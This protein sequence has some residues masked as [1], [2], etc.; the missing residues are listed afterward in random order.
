MLLKI[1][2]GN[3]NPYDT[4]LLAGS[5]LGISGFLSRYLETHYSFQK[6]PHIV[7]YPS[8]TAK[9]FYFDFFL[10]F[11]ANALRLLY[12]GIYLAAFLLAGRCLKNAGAS[13]PRLNENSHGEFK[14]NGGC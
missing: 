1:K 14:R 7:I 11:K 2:I 13:N 9:I 12:M 3:G 6:R 5:L 4:A 8:F 10:E